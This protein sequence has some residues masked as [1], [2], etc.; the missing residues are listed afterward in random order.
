MD[1]KTKEILQK[2]STQKVEL[3]LINEVNTLYDKGF[4]LY[5][6]QSELLKAQEKV[7]KSKNLFEQ[8]FKKAEEGIQY[9]KEI[10]ASDF[11]KLFQR[12]SDEAKGALKGADSLISAIDRAIS[13]L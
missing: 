9:S 7:K 13:I 4:D 6:V 1:S 11:I 3:S 10:G 5:D 2:F 8:S 12:K